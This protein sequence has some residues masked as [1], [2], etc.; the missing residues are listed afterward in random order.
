ML[1]QLARLVLGLQQPAGLSAQNETHTRFQNLHLSAIAEDRAPTGPWTALH[2]GC[3][4]SLEVEKKKKK[5][6][7]TCCAVSASRTEKTA[8]HLHCTSPSTNPV[9]G[10]FDRG[11][12]SVG[13]FF[14]GERKNAAPS[15]DHESAG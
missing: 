9:T 11:R 15:Q 2:Q 7:G 5:P 14:G 12:A 13:P 10:R 6:A 1:L 8:G 3:R 4:E